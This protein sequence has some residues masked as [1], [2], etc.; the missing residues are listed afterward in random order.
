MTHDIR[1]D[2][3]RYDSTQRI[4]EEPGENIMW[5][6]SIVN[7]TKARMEGAQD[8]RSSW[9]DRTNN[10]MT[11]DD[12]ELTN[13]YPKNNPDNDVA[14]VDEYLKKRHTLGI[15]RLTSSRDTLVDTDTLFDPELDESEFLDEE[16]TRLYQSLI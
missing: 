9:R 14:N 11:T 12:G 16:G 5:A 7:I 6:W 15:I 8:Y 13:S 3:T 10:I 2:S 4:F 1:R